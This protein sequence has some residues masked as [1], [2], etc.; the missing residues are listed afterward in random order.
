M[1]LNAATLK[2]ELRAAI[3]GADCG[4]VDGDALTNLCEAIATTVVAHVTTNA[5]VAFASV[6]TVIAP[7]GAAGGPCA[8][9]LA[10]GT[11]L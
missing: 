4:A 3:L 8:G 6:V 10:S 7:P 1:P 11:V 2:T 9:T 5:T